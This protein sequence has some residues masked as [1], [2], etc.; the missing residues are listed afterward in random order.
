M[1]LLDLHRALLESHQL[2]RTKVG[3][4][5]GLSFREGAQAFPDVRPSILSQW[6]KSHSR[7]NQLEQKVR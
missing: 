3:F 7:E 5:V 2:Q 4:K 1:L 6:A